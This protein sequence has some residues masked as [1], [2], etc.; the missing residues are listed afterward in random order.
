MVTQSFWTPTRRMPPRTGAPLTGCEGAA[1]AGRGAATVVGWL[2]ADAGSSG[3]GALRAHAAWPTVAN[4]EA[5]TPSTSSR[6]VTPIRTVVPL[7]PVYGA[8]GVTGC[9]AAVFYER[10]LEAYLHPPDR[11]IYVAGGDKPTADSGGGGD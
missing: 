6:R 3:D 9:G 8:M 11:Q 10:H 4:A 7:W 5:T 1:C 2:T